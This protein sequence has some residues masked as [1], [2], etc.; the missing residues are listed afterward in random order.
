MLENPPRPVVLC[1]LDGWGHRDERDHNAIAL[2]ETPVYDRLWETCPRAFLK[3]SAE[4]VGLPPGQMGNSEVGHTNI[5]A[6]RVVLQNLPRITAAIADGSLKSNRVLAGLAAKLRDSGGTCHLM[7]LVSPGGVHSH[8]D[9][10]AALARTVTE[11]GVPVAVHAFLDGRDTPPKSAGDYLRALEDGLAGT[12]ANV[13]TVSGRYY[14][15]DRDKRWE[16]TELAYRAIVMGRGERAGDPGRALS[17]AYEAGQSDEFVRPNV[18]GAYTGMADADGVLMANFRADRV[19]Q[20][21]AALV[22]PGFDGFDRQQIIS[23]AAAAGIVEYSAHL[24]QHVS[25]LFST[26]ALKNTLGEAVAAAGRKQLRIAETEKYAHVTFFFNG[27]EE[28]V[29]DGEER[30]LVPSP[31]V[32]T[33]DLKP[34]MSAFEVTDRL[35]EA[36]ES[37]R[38]D[39][40]VANFANADM[41][42]HTGDLDAAILA[43]Q[44]VDICLGRIEDAVG[45]AGGV[46]II[47]SDHGNAERMRD[48]ETG[49][50]HT[51]HTTGEVP[52]LVVHAPEAI[53]LSDGRLADVAPSVLHFL[54]LPQPDEMTGRCLIEASAGSRAQAHG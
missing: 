10:I 25:A 18:I 30:I 37:G 2:A 35:V 9:Q 8:Q 47:T 5:G 1:V 54:G 26:P 43:V 4:E 39:L 24:N 16:R 13:V 48:A 50:A 15:M 42:G 49:Q 12:G 32:A 6:G 27:G 33:Y 7:G 41:V 17:N 11:A 46:L 45:A 14:A 51:A 28:R 44:A 40:I 3:T 36:I 21:M 20:I 23:F 29:F 31:K 22:D 19:R 52:L 34:E 38:F 53:R